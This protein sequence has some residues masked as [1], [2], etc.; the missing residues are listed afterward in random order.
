MRKSLLV[1][2]FGLLSAQAALAGDS[3]KTAVGGGVGG[4]LGNVVGGA[5]GGSTGAAIGAGLGGA[6]GGAMTAKDGARP[7]PPWVAG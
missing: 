1:I 6:A 2:A 4:A 5:I 3:T 7:K